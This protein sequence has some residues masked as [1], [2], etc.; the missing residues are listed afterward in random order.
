MPGSSRICQLCRY[1]VSGR[2]HVLCNCFCSPELHI[3][4]HCTSLSAFGVGCFT[5]AMRHYDL[6]APGPPFSLCL[7]GTRSGERQ[8]CLLSSV[9]VLHERGGGLLPLPLSPPVGLQKCLSPARGNKELFVLYHMQ[10]YAST[11]AQIHTQSEV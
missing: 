5:P 6:L 4:H 7:E 8:P 9:I 10:V 1:L 2:R 11:C 3:H